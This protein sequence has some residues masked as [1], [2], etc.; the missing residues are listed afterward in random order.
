RIMESHDPPLAQSGQAPAVRAEGQPPDGRKWLART[1]LECVSEVAGRRIPDGHGA[2]LGPRHE[3]PAIDGAERHAQGG[4]GPTTRVEDLLAGRRVPDLQVTRLVRCELRP[5]RGNAP[6]V[7]AERQ[8]E[9]GLDMFAV[10]ED[11]PT[12]LRV[13]NPH[14][15]I[16]AGRGEAPAIG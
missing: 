14:G 9:Y 12:R 16:R 4:C 6:A 15:L 7:G 10:E 11:P 1:L 13:P 8:T 2:P 3:P 5:P